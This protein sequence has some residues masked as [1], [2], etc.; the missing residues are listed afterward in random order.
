MPK[1]RTP[2]QVWAVLSWEP[3]TFMWGKIKPDTFNWT[4]LYRRESSIY[5]PFT[6]WYKMTPEELKT[7]TKTKNTENFLLQKSKFASTMVSNCFDQSKRYRIIRELQRY[8]EVDNFGKCSGN[9]ICKAG[10]PT[11]ECGKMYLKDYK[12]YLA[13][14]N[15][16]CRDYVSEK[17]WNAL[18]R[19]QIPVIAA[20]KYT[21]ELL[22]PNS[23]LNVFDFPS[24]EALANR[25]KEI[26][27]NATLYNS[28]FD[29]MQFYKQ[30]QESVY[31]KLCRELH[32]NRPA[33][34]YVDMEGWIQD[35]MC[36]KSTVSK[37]EMRSG[38]TRFTECG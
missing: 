30:D 33:Q 18:D 37:L 13:F 6:T 26:A 3:M 19:H 16:F 21:L 34:S 17:F 31:C 35:D 11:T 8:V 5:N 9:I 36:Y 38:V 14:E 2:D 25:M 20:P 4:V 32:A 12:F 1:T 23:Y 7:N 22:P 24:I 28:F 10:I 15:S 29:W 27:N